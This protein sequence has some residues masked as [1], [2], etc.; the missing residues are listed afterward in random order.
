[1]RVIAGSLGGRTFDAPRGHR[2]HPMGDKIRGALFNIL[3]DITGLTV[4]DAFAGSGAISIEAISRGAASALAIDLDKEAYRTIKT[5][6][7]ALG[8]EERIT[9]M[10]KN[11]AGWSRNNQHQTFDIVVADPPYNDIRPV[12]LQKLITQIKP[13]GIFVISWPGNEPV[14]EFT[15]VEVLTAKSYG[16]AQLVFYKRNQ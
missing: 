3:G 2:T 15:G 14:R 4:L 11:V 7:D 10:R 5:N 1:M 12:L 13:G 9:V 16:D 8:L 6:V